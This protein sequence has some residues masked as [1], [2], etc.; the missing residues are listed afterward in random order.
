[1]FVL[2][3]VDLLQADLLLRV[4]KRDSPVL[5]HHLPLQLLFQV[6]RLLFLRL[7]AD[8][9]EA[10]LLRPVVLDHRVQLA[11]LVLKLLL[12]RFRPRLQLLD[13]LLRRL[14]RREGL[15]GL[16]DDGLHLV[17]LGGQLLLE[18]GMHLLGD[19]LLRAQVLNLRLELVVPRLLLVEPNQRFVQP[20]LQDLDPLLD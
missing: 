2:V 14:P 9:S 10:S 15:L 11:P 6:L 12:L 1:M 7:E 3:E 18:L 8:R 17:L 19:L 13:R 20:V 16:P 4:L 5:S